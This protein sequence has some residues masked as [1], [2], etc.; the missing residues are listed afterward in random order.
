MQNTDFLVFTTEFQRDLFIANY[1]LISKKP[2]VISNVFEKEGGESAGHQGNPKVIL[3][4]G[5]F[6][7]LK[8][9]DFLLKIFNRLAQYDKNLVLELIGSGPER[10]I[11][12]KVIENMKLGNKAKI[13]NG[14]THELLLEKIKNSYFCIL[15]SLS[16]ISPNFALQCLSLNK[17][18]VLTQETGIK[19]QFPG[20]MY[21]D[22]KNE[23]S[24]FS[25]ALR[26]LDKNSYD[27]YQKFI[28]DIRYRKTWQDLADEY[29][30]LLQ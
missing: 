17:P 15:P 3:W 9:L 23:D 18:I 21:G 13:I 12:A 6:I 27:N 28:F 4:A 22:P 29:L 20:L 26:L 5:R 14:I 7:K 8:N 19:N 16:E 11:I 25:T 30:N 2:L 10:N 24:L 1:N